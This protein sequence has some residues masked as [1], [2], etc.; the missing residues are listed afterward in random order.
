MAAPRWSADRNGCLPSDGLRV[1]HPLRGPGVIYKIDW[2]D[3]RGK[4]CIV[5]YD[6]KE[7]HHYNQHSLRKLHLEARPSPSTLCHAWWDALLSCYGRRCAKTGAGH[8]ADD[9]T[10]GEGF[11][12]GD[13]SP[14][15]PS[16]ATTAAAGTTGPTTPS[17]RFFPGKESPEPPSAQSVA[18]GT[19]TAAA[20]ATT[21]PAGA[22]TEPAGSCLHDQASAV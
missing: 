14:E 1:V 21:A 20:G 12:Q 8:E 7:R 11:V 5:H 3:P 18:T 13:E 2:D 19:T 15:S 17:E 22:T 6:N 16:G 4:P 10:R 9:A